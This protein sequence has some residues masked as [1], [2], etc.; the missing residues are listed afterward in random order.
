MWRTV[1]FVEHVDPALDAGQRL[2]ALALEA[3]QDPGGVLIPAATDIGGL[4]G[5][6]VDD[7]LRPLLGH[8]HQLAILEHPGGLL[9]CPGDDRVA[10]L[11]RSF[12]DAVASSVMRRACATSGGTATRNWS[13]SSRIAAWSSTT[14]LVRGSFLALAARDS[15]A[16]QGR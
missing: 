6:G 3:D 12:R 11:A 13:I 10:L 5:G 15:T 2:D 4:A 1:A 16:R 8:L 14:L 9:L 7:L